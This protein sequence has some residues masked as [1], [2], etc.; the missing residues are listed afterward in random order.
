MPQLKYFLPPPITPP[1]EGPVSDFVKHARS[2]LA[3]LT[4]G[5]IFGASLAFETLQAA[6]PR[7][8]GY[9]AWAFAAFVTVMVTTLL[10]QAVLVPDFR[11]F[12]GRLYRSPAGIVMALAAGGVSLAV[13]TLLL[14]VSLTK[15]SIRSVR[16]AGYALIGI[17]SLML[18]LSIVRLVSTVARR[19][20]LGGALHD[21]SLPMGLPGFDGC[22]P[23]L[24]ARAATH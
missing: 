8:Q 7:S 23:P 18:F 10:W 6:T 11:G 22:E 19:R 24:F 12:S 2:L 15:S 3:L 20:L 9:L 17:L 1:K 5:C 13:G 4:A 21:K 16:T 14:S